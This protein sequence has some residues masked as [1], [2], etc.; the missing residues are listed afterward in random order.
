MGRRHWGRREEGGAAMACVVGGP[1]S[2]L[3][4]LDLVASSFLGT[5]D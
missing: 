5:Q 4:D 3:P 1:G 2:T